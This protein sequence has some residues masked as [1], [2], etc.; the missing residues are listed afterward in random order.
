MPAQKVVAVISKKDP[1]NVQLFYIG[2][3]K[4]PL[5][6]HIVWYFDLL[7]IMSYCGL[8]W[9]IPHPVLV[10][11]SGKLIKNIEKLKALKVVYADSDKNAVLD[12]P[13]GPTRYP[14][15]G[16][17]PSALPYP[18]IGYYNL[19]LKYGSMFPFYFFNDLLYV[20]SDPR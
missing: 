7:S 17:L 12:I 18:S 2:H 20:C 15:V 8:K 19:A 13:E 14:V 16:N 4:V 5:E 1:S 10:D 11:I 9:N 3:E 6:P